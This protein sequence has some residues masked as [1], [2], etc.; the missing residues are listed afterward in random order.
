[1]NQ[2]SWSR[3]TAGDV[4]ASYT[5][6]FISDHATHNRNFDPNS[7]TSADHAG[8]IKQLDQLYGL[9]MADGAL[10]G[11]ERTSLSK[12]MTGTNAAMLDAY[13]GDKSLKAMNTE[14]D[15]GYYNPSDADAAAQTIADF[16]AA[17]PAVTTGGANPSAQVTTGGANPSAQVTTGGANPSA[18]VTTGG[19]NPSAQVTT[20]GANPSAQVTTGGANPSAQV[21]DVGQADAAGPQRAADGRIIYEAAPSFE[22]V[23]S[24]DATLGLGQKSAEIRDAQQALFDGGFYE[25]LYDKGTEAGGVA[26]TFYGP[27]TEQAVKAWQT[28]NGME[29]TGRLDGAALDKLLNKQS[30]AVT[31]GGANPSAQ[32]TTGG[33][34][35]SAQ[36]TTGGAN[37]SA[38]VTTGGANP[39]AQ[40]TT[41]GANPSAQVTTGG[42]NPSAQTYSVPPQLQAEYEG[43]KAQVAA[44]NGRSGGHNGRNLR[45]RLASLE[46]RV[47][48]GGLGEAYDQLQAERADVAARLE[49]NGSGHTGR[50]LRNRLKSLDAQ[51]AEFNKQ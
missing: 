28:A 42:A 12:L 15:A 9:A 36:V 26:D 24:G 46:Q 49:R 38:Q 22:A 14:L 16:E 8:A 27:K 31:T 41:G 19:A 32:V 11:E 37:P 20:G 13:Y 48:Q 5:K 40:V 3:V 34:N 2:P 30:P 51:L 1:M 44:L 23:R 17:Q 4:N 29:A 25:G 10:S 47:S 45:N 33:A 6:N 39:S 50:N 18:Q 43:V 21:A 7:A 35:P